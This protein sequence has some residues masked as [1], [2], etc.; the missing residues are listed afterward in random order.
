MQKRKIVLASKSP[1][2]KRLLEQ[3]GLEFEIVDSNYDEDSVTISDPV[4]LVKFLALKKAQ[5]VAANYD[6]AVVVGADTFTILD[7]SFIG[8][9]K[10]QADAKI[11]LKN[12]SGREHKVITGLAIIDTK[13]GN[14][15]NLAGEAMVKFRILDDQEIEDYIA[16]GEP[17]N[18]AGGYNM[19]DHGATLIESVSGDYFVIVGFPLSKLYVELRKM[20]AV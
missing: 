5:A 20:G 14:I 17:L 7:N 9:P 11:I 18:A 1:R 8:K 6:D 19:N 4:E 10:D 3:I 2:R 12:F 16:T 13:N 15:I